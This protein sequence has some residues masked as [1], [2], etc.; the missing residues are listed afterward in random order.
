MDLYL[1][2]LRFLFGMPVEDGQ[3][4]P[5]AVHADGRTSGGRHRLATRRSIQNIIGVSTP[6]QRFMQSTPDVSSF[7]ERW[8]GYLRKELLLRSRCQDSRRTSRI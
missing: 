1:M 2:I 5:I 3:L 7:Q 4:E 6:W 8:S